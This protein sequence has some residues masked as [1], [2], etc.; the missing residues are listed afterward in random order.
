M[1]Q[2]QQA[3]AG[4]GDGINDGN[5]DRGNVSEVSAVREPYK[6]RQRDVSGSRYQSYIWVYLQIA[7]SPTWTL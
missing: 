7:A 4:D 6:S 5:S 2:N 3:G 1:S